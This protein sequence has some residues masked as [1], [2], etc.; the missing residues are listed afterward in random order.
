M[1]RRRSKRWMGMTPLQIGVLGGMMA[2]WCL[3]L[4]GGWWWMNSIVAAAYAVPESLRMALTPSPTAILPTMTPLPLPTPMA[5]PTPIPYESLIPAGWKQFSAQGVEIWLPPT[6][7][8]Q[9]DKDKPVVQ[10]LGE[11][12]DWK[13]VLQVKDTV[14]GPYVVATTLKVVVRTLTMATLEEMVDEDLFLYT[15]RYQLQEHRPFVFQV[16]GYPAR[17]LLFGLSGGTNLALVLYAV[18]VEREVYY[19]GFVTPYN[20]LFSRLPDFDRAIQTFRGVT[21]P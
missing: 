16:S 21:V 13:T 12:P 1:R 11:N 9:T 14:A 10:V 2:G 5:S 17:R 20:E 18:Q 15:I 4:A 7:A 6:Y 8:L 19:L 3:V